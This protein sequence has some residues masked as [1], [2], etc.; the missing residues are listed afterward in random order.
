MSH[1]VALNLSGFNSTVND[2]S[3]RHRPPYQGTFRPPMDPQ[4]WQSGKREDQSSGN[5]RCARVS[6]VTC[7]NGELTTD[8][9]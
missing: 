7:A 8:V 5:S 1:A 6:E 3:Y 2:T 9:N 4:T